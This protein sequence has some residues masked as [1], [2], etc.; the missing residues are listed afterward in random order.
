MKQVIIGTVA[1]AVVAFIWG[2][3][4]WMALPWHGWTMNWIENDSPI[5]AAVKESITE[6]GVY[7]YP[8]M[9]K[10]MEGPAMEEFTKLHE[11]GPVIQLQVLPQG[12]PVMPP[13][14]WGFGFLIQICCAFLASFVLYKARSSFCCY[15]SRTMFVASLGLFAGLASD[16]QLWNWMHQP[17]DYSIVNLADKAIGWLLVGLVLA[18]IIKPAK[19]A[20]GAIEPTT[21][22]EPTKEDSD[23]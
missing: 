1:G 3:I 19:D 10:E 9:P 21:Q 12:A 18:A 23:T 11:A 22:T 14:M 7:F 16:M 6:P 2:M 20:A 13:S 4:S 17:L 5:A 15:P 8:N